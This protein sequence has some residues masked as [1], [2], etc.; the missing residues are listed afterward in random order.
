MLRA[1]IACA[2]LSSAAVSSADPA[3]DEDVEPPFEPRWL[4]GASLGGPGDKCCN[5]SS[6]V[7]GYGF[8]EAGVRPYEPMSL[9]A[10]AMLTRGRS[11]VEGVGA[12][13]WWSARVGPEARGC[14]YTNRVCA[15]VS[16]DL[17]Y[18]S[19]Y[20]LVA[21]VPNPAGG[22]TLA[23][24]APRRGLTLGGR[25]GLD[26]GW[27]YVRVRVALD[28]NRAVTGNFAVLQDG[29]PEDYGRVNGLDLGAV[30]TF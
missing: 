15:F 5:D 10:H 18:L 16:G 22:T 24:I 26:F 13:A 14:T 27:D 20:Q 6:F 4:V 19:V 8:V 23:P 21:D 17:G 12:A 11:G 3:R 28:F 1:A 9:W 7:A 30:A 25:F 2:V 29:A